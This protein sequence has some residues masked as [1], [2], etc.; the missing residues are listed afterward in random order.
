MGGRVPAPATPST[1]HGR[2]GPARPPKVRPELFFCGVGA[3]VATRGYPAPLAIKLV[4]V[5][6]VVVDAVGPGAVAPE[7][8][9]LAFVA[10]GEFVVRVGVDLDLARAERAEFGVP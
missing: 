6:V 9:A 5:A 7:H 10:K 8:P 3:V 1:S 4:L 2:R